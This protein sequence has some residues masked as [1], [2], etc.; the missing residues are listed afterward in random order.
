M[1]KIFLK[2]TIKIPNKD[3]MTGEEINMSYG[4]ENPS[5][6]SFVRLEVENAIAKKLTGKTEATK[7]LSLNPK[8][9]T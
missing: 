1:G 6:F 8:E 7:I 3:V 4:I 9:S 2:G 5:I